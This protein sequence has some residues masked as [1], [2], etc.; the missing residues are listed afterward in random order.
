MAAEKGNVD[1]YRLLGECHEH[2][3]QFWRSLSKAAEDLLEF[4]R[5]V[6]RNPH[7]ALSFYRKAKDDE[8]DIRARIRYQLRMKDKLGR[9]RDG[10]IQCK[11]DEAAQN[12]KARRMAASLFQS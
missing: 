12:P 8:D 11:L 7:S 2:G 5:G 9:S 6:E 3:F 10:N 4:G 1:D